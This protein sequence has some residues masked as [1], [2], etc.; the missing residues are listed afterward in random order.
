MEQRRLTLSARGGEV[1]L[2]PIRKLSP[3]ADDARKR[4]IEIFHLNIGQPDIKTPRPVIEAYRGYD[5]DVLAYSPSLG[6]PQLRQSI[7]GYYQRYGHPVSPQ[8]VAVT[9]GGSEAIFF[10][11]SAVCDPGDEILVREPFYANYIAF[12]AMI[13]AKVVPI[14]SSLDTG[15][16]LPSREEIAR[17]ITP[18][19]KAI[20]YI[21]PEN[22]TGIV[23]DRR[24][25]E[26]L[27]EVCERFGLY[28][29]S[30]E[31]YREFIYDDHV[32]FT[33]ILALSGFEQHAILIDSVS[34][35]FSCCGARIGCIVSFNTGVMELVDKFAQARLCPPTV[36]QLAADAAYRMDPSYFIPIREEYH[37]RRD[38]LVQG[39]RGIPGV[40]FN[41]PDGA[42]YLMARLPVADAEDFCR[43][44]LA[45]FS[46]NGRTV[47]LTPGA[48]F[49]STPDHGRD[50]VRMAYV[51]ETGKIEES[52]RIVSK[53]LEAYKDQG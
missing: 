40:T 14:P 1:P 11:L 24:E 5:A 30:D 31:V 10:A 26:T 48:G 23:Y 12:A 9:V 8:E 33:S 25:M 46:M 15:Y 6:I 18:R 17:Y 13:S 22:P 20:L 32:E 16:A 42:F 28:L 50:E 27:R 19:T 39:L 29:I 49:Y 35:R 34:K 52:V 38:T 43:F 37:R 47:M 51:L 53:A 41:V 36:G 7:S 3:L 2:S 21:S 4:G 45:D 44:L